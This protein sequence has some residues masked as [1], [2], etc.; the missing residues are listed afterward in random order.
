MSFE[1]LDIQL[2]TTHIDNISIFFPA[3]YMIDD[4][5]ELRMT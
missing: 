3:E 4:T 1:N 2:S 5:I